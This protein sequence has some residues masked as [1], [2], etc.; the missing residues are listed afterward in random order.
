MSCLGGLTLHKIPKLHLISWCGNFVERH[1]FRRVSDESSET[2][3][4]LYLSTKFPLQEIHCI[5]KYIK[6]IGLEDALVESK[7]IDKKADEQILNGTHHVRSL[8][9]M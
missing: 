3:R 6:G 7:L 5:G 8:R 9:T 2:L 1:S 4:K